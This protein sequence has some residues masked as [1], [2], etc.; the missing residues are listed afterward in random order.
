MAKMPPPVAVPAEAPGPRPGTLF[1]KGDWA[2]GCDNILSCKAVPLRPQDGSDVPDVLLE[3]LRDGGPGAPVALRVSGLE[4][5]PADLVLVIDGRVNVRF[6]QLEGDDVVL[7]GPDALAAARAMANATSIEVRTRKKTLLVAQTSPA[8]LADVLQFIDV[9]QGRTG[10]VG[11]LAIAGTRD[12]SVVPPAPSA[13]VIP[14]MQAPD[15]DS[16]PSLSPAELAAARRLAVCDASLMAETVAELFPLDG[17]S[18]L[19]LLPC[20]A[21]AYNV[22]AVPLIARGKPGSRTLSIARFDIAPGFTGEPGKPPLVVNALW[23]ARRGVLSSLAKGR[24][25][26][27]CGAS[28]DYVWD[29]QRFRLIESEAMHVCRGAWDWIRLWHGQ[30]GK[31]APAISARAP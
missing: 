23:D 7:R 12:E 3:I 22:S 14:Q 15:A 21:G 31:A 17:E 18:A 19:L 5:L 24:G 25:I 11:A 30:P 26:G 28:E 16:A 10:T 20:E 1:Y 13:P 27:D 9:R 2:A 4:S 8:G 29:G 6:N